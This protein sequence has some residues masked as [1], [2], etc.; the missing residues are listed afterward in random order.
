MCLI[1][2]ALYAPWLS[3]PLPASILGKTTEPPTFSGATL[4]QAAIRSAIPFLWRRPAV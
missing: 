3:F 1:N 2:G 4:G